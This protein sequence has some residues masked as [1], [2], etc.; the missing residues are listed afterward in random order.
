[1]PAQS[2]LPPAQS[3]PD[4]PMWAKAICSAGPAPLDKASRPLQRVGSSI[5]ILK[6]VSAVLNILRSL[7][8]LSASA[9]EVSLP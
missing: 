1:M 2:H 8:D 9:S 5:V 6:R 7:E 3:I 4:W